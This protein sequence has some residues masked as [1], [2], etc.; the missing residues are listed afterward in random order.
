MNKATIDEAYMKIAL[1]SAKL[2][3]ESGEVPIGC[4]IVDQ[5]VIVAEG[6]NC[7]EEKQSQLFHAEI[8]ALRKT[9][10][11]VLVDP[12]IYITHE[13]CPMCLGAIHER[14]I[15]N[16]VY[17]ADEPRWGTL[18]S[19]VDLSF[20]LSINVQRHVLQQECINIIKDFFRLRRLK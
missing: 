17:G 20:D 10:D 5:G 6:H 14:G 4:V 16:I 7:C 3:F 18:G 12:T 9:Q 13:P 15:K 1:K 8:V 11:I 2:S 19:V